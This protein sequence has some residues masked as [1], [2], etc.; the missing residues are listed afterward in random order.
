MCLVWIVQTDRQGVKKLKSGSN[1]LRLSVKCKILKKKEEMEK[2]R[3]KLCDI[4]L[5]RLLKVDIVLLEWKMSIFLILKPILELKCMKQNMTVIKNSSH[6]FLPPQLCW[7]SPPSV[8]PHPSTSAAP[9]LA[10]PAA[11]AEA[12]APPIMR[13]DKA[14]IY[15]QHLILGS[16]EKHLMH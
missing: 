12:A 15:L 6:L 10:P 3:Q 9:T 1:D 14:I 13:V 5:V 8:C 2:S 7:G 11:S 4:C 16:R